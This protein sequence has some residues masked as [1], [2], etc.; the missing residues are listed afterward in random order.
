MC[1]P[2]HWFAKVDADKAVCAGIIWQ[3]Y[4]S[5]NAGFKDVA[6]GAFR[7][8]DSRALAHSNTGPKTKS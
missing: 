8:H 1:L 5:T 3:R 7:R 6:T 2:Q 4:A